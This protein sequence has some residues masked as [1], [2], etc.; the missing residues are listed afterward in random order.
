MFLLH[1]LRG[2]FPAVNAAYL[3]LFRPIL[4]THEEKELPGAF[5]F[6]LGCALTIGFFPLDIAHCS[7][8]C[9]ALGDPAGSLFGN[10]LGSRVYDVPPFILVHKTPVKKTVAG[11][12][13]TFLVCFLTGFIYYNSTMASMGDMT[14]ALG[15]PCPS[16]ACHR[17]VISFCSFRLVLFP[18]QDDVC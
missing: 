15:K 13:G 8:L 10:L 3:N 4:R 6:L 1:I 5:Y 18:F 9:L 7:I 2:M 14:E 11:L 16:M 12:V 17:S